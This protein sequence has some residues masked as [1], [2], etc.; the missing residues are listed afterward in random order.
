MTLGAGGDQRLLRPILGVALLVGLVVAG[1]VATVIALNSTLYSPGGF[2]RSYLD[3]LARHDVTEALLADGVA[4]PSDASGELLDP[5]A[6]G[7]LAGIRLVSD[8]ESAAPAPAGSDLDPAPAPEELRDPHRLVFEFLLDGRP[9]TAEFHVDRAGSR[10]G[11]FADWRFTTSPTTTLDVSPVGVTEFEANGVTMPTGAVP[12]APLRYAVLVPGAFALGHDSEL[13]EAAPVTAVVVDPSI[14]ATATI[15]PQATPAFVDLVQSEL[16]A[17]LDACTGQTVLQPTGCPFGKSVQ[18]RIQG[19][20]AW[21][22]ADYPDVTIQPGTTPGTWQV[23]P[24]TGA[25]HLEVGVRSLF[26]GSLSTLDEDVPFTVAYLISFGDD[27]TVSVTA[28]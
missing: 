11:L 28:E 23:P 5:D 1:F 24:T 9:A 19:E 6:L 2:A 3:A 13:L 26:D 22:I 14:P 4:V 18:N 15:L 12:G 20:P 27:G 7:D 16:D 10:F 21:T 17:V 25:A 8:E